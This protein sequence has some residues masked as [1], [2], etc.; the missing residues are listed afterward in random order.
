ML[1]VPR[2]GKINLI[3]QVVDSRNIPGAD[4]TLEVR[5]HPTKYQT[6]VT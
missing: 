5:L 4:D 2:L 6:A 1:H 3:V